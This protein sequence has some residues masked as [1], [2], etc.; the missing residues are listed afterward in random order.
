MFVTTKGGREEG[1]FFSVYFSKETHNKPEN[2]QHILAL[3]TLF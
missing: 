3:K 2:S 1:R